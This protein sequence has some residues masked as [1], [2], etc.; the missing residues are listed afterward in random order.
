VAGVSNPKP[1]GVDAGQ[2]AKNDRPGFWKKTGQKIRKEALYSEQNG[3]SGA[4]GEFIECVHCS[5]SGYSC[6]TTRR[7]IASW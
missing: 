5:V 7:W 3:R 1:P 2:N 4:A 6:G